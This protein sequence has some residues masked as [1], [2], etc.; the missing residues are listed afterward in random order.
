MTDMVDKVVRENFGHIWSRHVLALTHFLIACRK[1]F[2]GDIDLFLV[3]CV[4]GERT[5]SQSNVREAMSYE[6]WASTGG[7]GV[8]PENINVQ[9]I[10]DFSGIPRETVRRKFSILLEKGWV[11]R[12]ENGFICATRKAQEE[13]EPLTLASMQYLSKMKATFDSV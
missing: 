6:E 11:T 4:V 1:S 7:K 10:S 5:F 12:D 3:L 9:S 13:L 2:E 8:V